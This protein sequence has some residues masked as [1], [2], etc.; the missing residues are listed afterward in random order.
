V[1]DAADRANAPGTVAP[2]AVSGVTDL[3]G[4]MLAGRYRLLGVIGSGASGRV[5]VADDTRLRR[6]VAVKVLHSALADDA[7]FLRRFR[8]EAQLAASL[9]HPNV[10]TV[11]DWGEDIVPF[12]VL[13]LLEGGSLRGI[14]DAGTRLTP[15]QA[16]HVGRQVTEALEYAH[17]RGLVHRD[18]KP[19]NLLYDEH[20]IVRVA[21]FGLARALAEASLTEPS[22]SVLGTAR[23]ASPEQASGAALDGRSD[24]YALSL[25]LVEAVTGRVPFVADT[26]IGTLAAR[27]QRPLLAPAGL[28]ALAPVIERAGHVDPDQRYPNAATMRDALRDASRQ[29]PPPTPLPLPGL[30]AATIEDP[31]PTQVAR[32]RANEVFDQDADP[33]VVPSR[34][35]AERRHSTRQWLAP[36]VVAG[37]VV[38]LL[39]GATALLFRSGS[40]PVTIP[41]LVGLESAAAEERAQEAGFRVRIAEREGTD[42]AGTVLEQA[43]P[44]GSRVSE[45]ATLELVV[46]LGPPPAPLPAIA[47]RPLGEVQPELEQAGFVIEVKRQFDE[48]V[49]EDVVL[50]TEPPGLTEAP[51][52]SRIVLVVSDGPAPVPV[53]DV[54]GKTYEEAAAAL[55]AVNLAAAP[56]E[57]FSQTIDEGRVIGTDPPVGVEAPRDSTVTV[58][59]SKGPP[60][61]EVPDVVGASVEDATEALQ[62]Q[63]LAADVRR[64]GAG[65][66]VRSMSPRAGAVVPIGTTVT[67]RL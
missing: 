24:L 50:D 8:K 46:S 13:E 9:H 45:G 55:E 67:L 7:G 54:E 39:A 57:N 28:D 23:Y 18:I 56:A 20:G 35:P 17:N 1:S 62:A 19:A 37:L 32:A 29:L 6:R 27:T 40:D 49:R 12:M 30:G 43:P 41:G 34:R 22:G 3:A 65:R 42:P 63:G 21:D 53:P 15:A 38:A 64:Y 25:V 60:L 59:V 4:R 51:P 44:P 66:P 5:Y 48:E 61:V 33:R 14:L 2:M 10:V 26:P 36:A 47:G 52:E 16:A 58:V 11:F 31:H